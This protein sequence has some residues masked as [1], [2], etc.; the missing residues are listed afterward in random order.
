VTQPHY[1]Q[2]II[3]W[4]AEPQGETTPESTLA[5][6]NAELAKWEPVIREAG[7]QPIG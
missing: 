5:F 2:K 1:R 7:I 6:L 3:E 4:G